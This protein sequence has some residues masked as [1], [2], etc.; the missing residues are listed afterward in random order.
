MPV[1]TLHQS[2]SN[3]NPQGD[4]PHQATFA[5]PENWSIHLDVQKVESLASAVNR[6]TLTRDPQVQGD[7]KPFAH[8]VADH[9]QGVLEMIQVIECDP[10]LNNAVLRSEVTPAQN[11]SVKYYEMTITGTDEVNLECFVFDRATDTKREKVPFAFTN[12]AICKVAGE[13]IKAGR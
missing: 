11:A 5:L 3:W 6:L 8:S 2:L 4:G 12:D 10:T 1:K 13:V 9:L 7:L